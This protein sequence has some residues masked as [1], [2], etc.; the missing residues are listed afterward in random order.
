MDE[1]TIVEALKVSGPAGGLVVVLG[2][3]IRGWL[4]RLQSAVDDLSKRFGKFEASVRERLAK[5]EAQA[6]E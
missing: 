5:L 2:I 6:D 3:M 4:I 1:T